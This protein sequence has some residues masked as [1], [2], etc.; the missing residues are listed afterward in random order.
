MNAMTQHTF[1]VTTPFVSTRLVLMSAN[2]LM[3][4]LERSLNALVRNK[5]CLLEHDVFSFL[6]FLI[7]NLLRNFVLFRNGIDVYTAL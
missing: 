5:N 1:V 7:I 3:D 2:V 6:K 4:S